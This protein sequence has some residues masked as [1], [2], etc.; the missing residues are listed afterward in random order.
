MKLRRDHATVET[1][2]PE[3]QVE[4]LAR[5]II[6]GFRPDQEPNFWTMAGERFLKGHLASGPDAALATLR[7]IQRCPTEHR[8]QLGQMSDWEV[9]LIH[10]VLSEVEICLERYA[11]RPKK[12][13]YAKKSF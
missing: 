11:R 3:H 4:L 5:H 2:S 12:E 8:H 1:S 6:Y 13:L 7:T 10:G 9:K